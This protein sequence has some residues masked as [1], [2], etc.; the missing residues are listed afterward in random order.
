MQV[1]TRHLATF[2][3]V[4]RHSSVGK[5]AAAMHVTQPAVTRTI[6]ELEHAVGAAL[7]ERDGRGLRLTPAGQS[8]ARHAAT[9][10][11]ALHQGV[12]AARHAGDGQHAALRIGALPTVSARIMPDAVARLLA[13]SDARVVI[14]TGEN[15]A[16]TAQ[17]RSGELDAVVGRMAAPEHMAGL[18][19]E[20]LYSERVVFAVRAGH[21]LLTH[22]PFDPKTVAR[23]PIVVPTRSAII[24]PSVE[25]FLLAHLPHLSARIESVSDSFGRA[26]LRRSDA[27]WI[28]SEGVVTDDVTAGTLA[29]L[30][31]DTTETQGAVGLTLSTERDSPP[32]LAPFMQALRGVLSEAPH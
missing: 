21:P 19:F 3:E 4:A 23:Y 28:I 31:F 12:E 9:S 24:R 1:K 26:F 30:P 25:R 10:L 7:V 20:Y 17:L 13:S 11:A 18:S 27:I 8:F 14:V 32:P 29:L 6:R 16:L 22:A 15:G 5:A 2:L